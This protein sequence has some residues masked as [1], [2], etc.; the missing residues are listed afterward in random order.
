MDYTKVLKIVKRLKARKPDT[1]PWDDNKPT[2]YMESDA[3]WFESNREAMIE[4]IDLLD[5]GITGQQIHEAME[6]VHK[7]FR[8]GTSR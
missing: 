8:S 5:E 2:G 1:D 7:G 4:L 3:D 6:E